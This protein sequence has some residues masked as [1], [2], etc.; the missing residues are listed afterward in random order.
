MDLDGSGSEPTEE[1]ID[2]FWLEVLITAH[3]QCDILRR[4][5]W[6][7]CHEDYWGETSVS[8]LL[9]HAERFSALV[10]NLRKDSEL[11]MQFY[12]KRLKREPK[13]TGA[14]TR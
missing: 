14:K 1:D 3:V 11:V 8:K 5:C 12:A 13:M 4:I 6:H 2:K 9:A 10:D 7:G